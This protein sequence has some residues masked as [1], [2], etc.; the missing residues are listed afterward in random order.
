MSMTTLFRILFFDRSLTYKITVTALAPV[1][2]ML[3]CSIFIGMSSLKKSVTKYFD[4]KQTELIQVT[5]QGLSDS[6]SLADFGF[7]SSHFTLLMEE[8]D[9]EYAFV[10]DGEKRNIL[11]HSNPDLRGT[12]YI[13]HSNKQPEIKHISLPIMEEGKIVGHVVAGFSQK[14]IFRFFQVFIRKQLLVGA[15]I[16]VVGLLFYYI[17]VRIL[18][19][20]IR[21][22]S[23]QAEKIGSGDDIEPVNYFGQDAIGTF[24]HSFNRVAERLD[25]TLLSLK[26][27]R[28]GLKETVERQTEQLKESV[29]ELQF[30][31]VRLETALRSRTRFFS[32][33]SH[34]LRTP[35]NGILGTVALLSEKHFG[36]LNEKQKEYVL[37]IEQSG[38]HLLS[39]V[40]DT[41]DMAKID[42]D[43]M[44]LD[45]S[46]FDIRECIE[47]TLAM[48]EGIFKKNN[49][50]LHMQLEDSF[51]VNADYRR[52]RQILFNLVANATQFTKSG[53]TV[54]VVLEKDD[55]VLRIS[56]IDTGIGMKQED[57][58]SIFIPFHQVKSDEEK[59]VAGTGLGLMLSKGLVEMHGGEIRVES[60]PKKGSTFWFTLP[61]PS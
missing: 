15:V 44:E 55:T 36:V 23:R 51:P 9:I 22:I 38:T 31:N 18:T 41:L 11:I 20:S 32:S 46:V 37:Q 57:L 56:V 53:G 33:I 14:K 28:A 10:L 13:P 16:L 59:P 54:T 61:C 60:Q 12:T 5:A 19:S 24:V 27:E 6:K 17:L 3:L 52:I 42:V 45:K 47:S 58:N 26:K 49:L 21:R 43:S 39:L 50:I 40:N 35:L 34:E 30:T 8:P 2:I 25:T 1:L 7:V 48:M 29:K 4:L